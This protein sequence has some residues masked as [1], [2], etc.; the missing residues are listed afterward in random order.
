MKVTLH[1]DRCEPGDELT[2]AVEWSL[3]VAPR[4]VEVRLLWFT[5]GKGT[6]DAS[7]V[8]TLKFESPRAQDRREFRFRLP[9]A[10]YSYTGKLIE[11]V[12]AVELVALPSKESA[13][14]EFVLAPAG[15]PVRA[16]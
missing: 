5:R 2:G 9:A 16:N 10:P 15:E 7:V 1:N 13:R 4:A 6:T 14:A 12:W 11:V 3:P 8:E